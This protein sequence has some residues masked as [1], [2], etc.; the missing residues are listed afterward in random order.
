MLTRTRQYS[1]STPLL[2]LVTRSFYL[3]HAQLDKYLWYYQALDFPAQ[4]T[5]MYGWQVGAAA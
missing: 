1:F 5:D 2:A 3:H 4:L